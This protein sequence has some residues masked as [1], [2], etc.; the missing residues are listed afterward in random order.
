MRLLIALLVNMMQT[1]H[2]KIQLTKQK[3]CQIGDSKQREYKKT[4]SLKW[5]IHIGGT[6]KIRCRN[7]TERLT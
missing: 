4:G 2:Y 3:L 1:A 5:Q 6:D 7:K